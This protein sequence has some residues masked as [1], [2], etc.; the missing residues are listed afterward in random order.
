MSKLILNPEFKLYERN[1]QAFCSS[2]QVAEEFGN[3]LG[4]LEAVVHRSYLYPGELDKNLR[5]L[6]EAEELL[7]DKYA[8][9]FLRNACREAVMSNFLYIRISEKDIHAWFKENVND[10]LGTYCKIVKRKNDKHHIPDFWI[11]EKEAY[12]PVKIKLHEFSQRHLNQILRYMN[13]YGCA[14]GIAV[15]AELNCDLP[16]NVIFISYNPKEVQTG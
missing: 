2:R 8:Y 4:K 1:G 9:P 15:A 12:V 7:P 10:L 6:D 16:S 5:L 14:K 11:K 13:F 3:A